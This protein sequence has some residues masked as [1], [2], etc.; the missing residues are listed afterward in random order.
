MH[1]V[2]DDGTEL[3]G[4][5]Q[6]ERFQAHGG[7]LYAVGE[8]TGALGTSAVT[9]NN[10]RI[11][12]NG[13][14]EPTTSAAGLVQ[15]GAVLTMS[16]ASFVASPLAARLGRERLLGGAVGLIAL[17]S[18]VRGIAA[19]PALVGGSVLV[20]FGI[21]TAGVLITGVVKE[22]LPERAGAVSGAYVVSM[23]I[24]ATVSSAVAAG[25]GPGADDTVS[26]LARSSRTNWWASLPRGITP[27][28][29]N[30][31]WR[32]TCT[33]QPPDSSRRAATR[34]LS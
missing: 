25:T 33:A 1:G 7:V 26:A 12:V 5:F 10:V 18:L 14:A 29:A 27:A 23:M 11:P 19:L 28:A 16:L 17:G 3:V 8:L 34:W 31:P 2:A 13:A 21:G 20:G 32:T 6:L 24:G 30:R 22:H 9:K 15:A 4:T